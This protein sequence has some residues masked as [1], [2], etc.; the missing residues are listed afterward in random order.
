LA[1]LP[2]NQVYGK[3]A[4]SFRSSPRASSLRRDTRRCGVASAW[5]H[6]RRC[7]RRPLL[8]GSI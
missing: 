5:F 8:S 2:T 7:A 6:R 3:S 4:A 1:V